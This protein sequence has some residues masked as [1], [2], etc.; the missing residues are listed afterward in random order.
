MS[1]QKLAA[2]RATDR[3]KRARRRL[4]LFAAEDAAA[5]PSSLRRPH[6]SSQWMALPEEKRFEHL[7]SGMYNNEYARCLADVLQN[8][9]A[10]VLAY[11]ELSRGDKDAVEA[12]T[13]VPPA[14]PVPVPKTVPAAAARYSLPCSTCGEYVPVSSPRARRARCREHT[15]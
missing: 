9:P 1:P 13:Y 15:E 6:T 5:T 10:R 3:V 14:D 11:L 12:G 7:R 8:P 4:S 2:R